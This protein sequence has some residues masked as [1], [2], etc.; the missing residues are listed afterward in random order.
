MEPAA[1][2]EALR[3]TKPATSFD[4]Q[5]SEAP[6]WFAFTPPRLE[7]DSRERHWCTFHRA[8]CAPSPA[9]AAMR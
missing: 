1:A 6:V 4:T 3:G 8:I 9:G 5:L 7:N 2:R